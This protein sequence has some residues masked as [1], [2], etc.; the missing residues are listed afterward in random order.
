[1]SGLVLGFLRTKGTE[2]RGQEIGGRSAA[3]VLVLGGTDLGDERAGD[4][5]G[6]F[7]GVNGGGHTASKVVLKRRGCSLRKGRKK[8]EIGGACRIVGAE[9]T[10]PR[11]WMDKR[12]QQEP[13]PSPSNNDE[14]GGGFGNLSTRHEVLD[15]D[16]G[17]RENERSIIRA[18][19]GEPKVPVL[20]CSVLP[21]FL[22]K[23][24]EEEENVLSGKS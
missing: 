21:S 10:R 8:V 15:A 13:G 4:G 23:L 12:K 11:S 16:Y 9:N 22:Q 6:S 20:N 14:S 5:R 24:V 1:M 3:R 2:D 7:R 18:T 19:A 17:G